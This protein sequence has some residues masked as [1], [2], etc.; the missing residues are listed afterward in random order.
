MFLQYAILMLSNSTFRVLL[1]SSGQFSISGQQKADRR[2]GARFSKCR[3]HEVPGMSLSEGNSHKN[4]LKRRQHLHHPRFSETIISAIWF[5][6]G[7][8]FA[9]DASP[10]AVLSILSSASTDSFMVA[11]SFASSVGTFCN[12][13][14]AYFFG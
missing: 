10:F 5:S 9:P 8:T 4:H 14:S 6:N 2:N 11:M 12:S 7:P 1:S 13:A 3:H